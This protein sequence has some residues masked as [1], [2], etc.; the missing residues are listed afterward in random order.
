MHIAAAG[1]HHEVASLLIQYGA[2]I[3]AVDDKDKSCLDIAIEN[4]REKVATVLVNHK[5]L[6]LI[7]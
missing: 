2:D 6:V 1:G 4:K 7:S 5:E 3:T